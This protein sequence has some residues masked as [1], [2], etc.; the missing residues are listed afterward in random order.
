VAVGRVGTVIGPLFAGLLIAKGATAE[1]VILYLAPMAAVSGV[2][3][4][5]LGRLH[6]ARPR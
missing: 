3:V 2:A 6:G 4:L 5:A 1:S